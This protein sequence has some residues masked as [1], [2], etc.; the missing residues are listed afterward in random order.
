MVRV[1]LGEPVLKGGLPRILHGKPFFEKPELWAFSSVGQSSRLITGRSAVRAREGP[2][3]RGIAQ[4]VE[5]RSPKPRAEGSSPSAPARLKGGKPQN[6]SGAVVQL[7]RTPACHAGG[8]GFKSLPRRHFFDAAIAQSVE[9]ILG[10]DEVP[11]SNLGSSSKIPLES[12]DSGGIF[13]AFLTF[14]LSLFLR[15]LVD[16]HRDPHA[17]MSGEA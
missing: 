1:Q 12:F 15:F 3:H 10:K 14:W 8:R 5:Q 2:P 6:I 13:L 17:E 4:L 11:S 16:P 7:V 9:R